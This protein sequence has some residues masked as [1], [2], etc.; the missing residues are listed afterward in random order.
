MLHLA[1][2]RVARLHEFLCHYKL[3]VG[4]WLCPPL[5]FL[6]S[7]PSPAATASDPPAS[8]RVSAGSELLGRVSAGSELL[9]GTYNKD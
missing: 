4:L 3:E 8:G 7:L 1:V 6:P 9:V 5:S 2:G